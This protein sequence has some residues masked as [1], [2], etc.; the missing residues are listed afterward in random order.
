MEKILFEYIT[1]IKDSLG[2][3]LNSDICLGRDIRY[4]SPGSIVFFPLHSDTLFCGL[5]G[6]I[7]LKK[8][9]IEP[10]KAGNAKEASSLFSRIRKSGLKEIFSGSVSARD[11]LQCPENLKRLEQYVSL[12]R[13]DDHFRDIF[14]D[15]KKAGVLRKLCFDIK[16]FIQDQEKVLEDNAARLSTDEL[17]IVNS[18]IIILKDLQW[19]L[20]RD[21]LQNIEKISDLAQRGATDRGFHPGFIQI[22]PD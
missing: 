18:R 5:A 10:V 15:G 17:E 13:L 19:G 3:V 7:T 9:E 20:E 16:E 6:I 1:R 11:Y 2:A 8:A 22:Q 21:I 14:F 4:A 12:W